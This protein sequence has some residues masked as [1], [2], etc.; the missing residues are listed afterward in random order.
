LADPAAAANLD[1]APVTV[2]VTDRAVKGV[3]AVPI[4]A[5]VALACGGYGVLVDQRAT[6]GRRLVAVTPGL[7]ATTLVQITAGAGSLQAGD[8]VEVPPQ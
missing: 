1:A 3:L 4:T 8:L 5:L 7:F 2:N 6:P